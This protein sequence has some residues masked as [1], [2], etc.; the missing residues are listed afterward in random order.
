MK[1]RTFIFLLGMI[2]LFGFTRN[3]TRSGLAGLNVE[4]E[5][6]A[7]LKTL[8]AETD[9][10]FKRDYVGVIKYYVHEDYAF[11][12]WNN[13]D[14]TYSATVGWPAINANFKNYIQNNPVQEGSYS[15]P[16]V[17]RH[18]MIFKFFSPELA[19]VTWDQ[20][21]SD[22]S[23]KTFQISKETRIMEKQNGL[24]K[25]ANMTALWDY[26]N[27]IPADIN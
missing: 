7:I 5:K 18:D 2:A 16:K 13:P 19:F 8:T 15:H 21:N 22:Q 14:G 26:K 9:N 23:M 25:I 24:W 6:E 11:H 27:K 4:K 10:F 3:A 17:K 20:Y 12:A 1:T